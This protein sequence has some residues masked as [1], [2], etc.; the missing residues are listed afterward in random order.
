MSGPEPSGTR[1]AIRPAG[2]RRT[3]AEITAAINPS[4]KR[5]LVTTFAFPLL[6]LLAVPFWWYVTSIVRLPLPIE[7]IEA[8]ERSTV[9]MQVFPMS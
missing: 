7:R 1:A 3:P 5:R 8:L 2:E 4:T 6:I 9:S